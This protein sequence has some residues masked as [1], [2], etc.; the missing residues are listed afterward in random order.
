M[1]LEVDDSTDD[2]IRSHRVARLATAS[3]QGQP[4]VVPICYVFDGEHI[5]TPIDQKPKSVEAGL[6]RRVRNINDNANIALVI[7]DYSEDWNELTYVLIIGTAKVMSPGDSPTEHRLAVVSLREKYRQYKSMNIDDRPIIK[8][9]P[10]RIKR[11]KSA[12]KARQ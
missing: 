10:V 7:D 12:E 3:P 5:Y 4:A 1:P 11:W 2:F 8:I 6:L 9:S